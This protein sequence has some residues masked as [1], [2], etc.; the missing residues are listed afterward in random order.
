MNPQKLF[1]LSLEVVLKTAVH[2]FKFDGHIW[3]EYWTLFKEL[4][5]SLKSLLFELLC[6]R[7]VISDENINYLINP[8]I[9]SISLYNCFKSDFSVNV[10]AN[11]CK[12][13]TKLNL[14]AKLPNLNFITSQPLVH[15]FENSPNIV[16]LNLE[17]CIQVEDIVIESVACNCV[18]IQIIQ[19]SGCLSLSDRSVKN[20]AD[21]CR[22]LKCLNLSRTQV[23]D[24]G[25]CYLA[26][27]VCASV[28]TELLINDCSLVSILSIRL[29]AD[30]C[31][32]LK[33]FSFH[34][35]R[36]SL[37]NIFDVI[38]RQQNFLGFQIN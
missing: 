14:G 38:L 23:S 11:T 10:I 12:N 22:H 19:L 26:K 2:T 8:S 15:L 6:R 3:K 36:A 13:I 35:T 18:N 31:K 7:E 21:C 24:D 4:P 33:I 37:S 20:L 28:L 29:L 17:N 5:I 32:N 1:D 25:L 9:S 30:N 34:G 27:G 16:Y